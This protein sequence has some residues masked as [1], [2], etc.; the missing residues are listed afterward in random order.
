MDE[1]G[2]RCFVGRDVAVSTKNMP[3][4]VDTDRESYRLYGELRARRQQVSAMLSMLYV[5]NLTY[6][7]HWVSSSPLWIAQ[8]LCDLLY[9]VS[10]RLFRLFCC[11]F[12]CAG[13]RRSKSLTLLFLSNQTNI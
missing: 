12:C 10:P 8:S 5:Y 9:R 3:K 7:Y 4:E 11:S 6:C 13:G 1:V 2:S